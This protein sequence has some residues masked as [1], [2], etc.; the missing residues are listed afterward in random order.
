MLGWKITLFCVQK[1]TNQG[2]KISNNFVLNS[3]TV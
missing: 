2:H 3:R 1:E